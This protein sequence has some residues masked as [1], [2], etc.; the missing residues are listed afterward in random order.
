MAGQS[1]AGA[2]STS[3][4]PFRHARRPLLGSATRGLGLGAAG[5]DQGPLQKYPHIATYLCVAR[6]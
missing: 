3:V 4:V 5:F 2:G 1:G 6:S